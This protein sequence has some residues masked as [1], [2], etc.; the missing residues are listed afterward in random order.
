M[1]S[2]AVFAITVSK[3]HNNKLSITQISLVVFRVVILQLN[4]IFSL[5]LQ[6]LM[7]YT[8]SLIQKH[9]HTDTDTHTLSLSF[10]NTHTHSHLHLLKHIQRNYLS[11]MKHMHTQTHTLS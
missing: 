11:L 9:T 1:T 4:E 7:P 10:R 8:H 5:T 2:N 3:T 6:F